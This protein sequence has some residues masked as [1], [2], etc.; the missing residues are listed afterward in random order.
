LSLN[1]ATPYARPARLAFFPLDEELGLNPFGLTPRLQQN[2]VRLSTWMPFAKAST[3]LAY[4]T[5]TQVSPATTRRLTEGTGADLVVAQEQQAQTLLAEQ[6]PSPPGPSL[7]LLSVDGAMVPLLGG[8]WAEVKTLALGEVKQVRGKDR[9]KPAKTVA[10]SYFSRT[11]EAAQFTQQAIVETHRRGVESTA[12]V[13][14]VTDGAVWQ[15][16]FIDYHRV[17]AVRI[18]DFA[19]ASEYVAQCGRL[20]YEEESLGFKQWFEKQCRIL[21][22]GDPLLVLQELERL[23]KKSAR[24]GDVC[25]AEVIAGSLSYFG[26]RRQMI[27]YAKFQAQGYPIGSGSVESA[28]KVVVESRLKQAGMRWKR[29][30]VDP[31]LGL[32]NVACNQRWEEAWLEISEYQSRQV[33]R[34]R[35]ERREKWLR[36]TAESDGPLRKHRSPAKAALKE[37]QQLLK[38]RKKPCR[39]G[40]YRPPSDHPWRR[41]AI[42]RARYKSLTER[43][44]AKI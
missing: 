1:A 4:L 17:D 28:N 11:L 41:M 9:E 12:Q 22:R 23:R 7:Q 43:T 15:Q 21:K 33:K 31:M 20:H 2:L 35:Q 14:A 3:E 18:L 34:Q 26:K 44:D 37:L 29:E 36:K 39:Q 38:E 8:E 32:R 24:K 27:E 6:T 40:S 25:G 19:H 10:L 30:N 13:C 42:G 5:G 16:G